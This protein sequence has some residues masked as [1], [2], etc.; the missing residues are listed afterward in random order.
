MIEQP[1][2]TVID[3]AIDHSD[4][5]TNKNLILFQSRTSENQEERTPA[6]KCGEPATQLPPL[7]FLQSSTSKTPQRTKKPTLPR[8]RLAPSEQIHL[9][10]PQPPPQRGGELF[11]HF[12]TIEQ[13]TTQNQT[14]PPRHG[15]PKTAQGQPQYRPTQKQGEKEDDTTGRPSRGR[16]PRA[17]SHLFLTALPSFKADVRLKAGCGPSA[18]DEAPLRSASYPTPQFRSPP[19]SPKHPLRVTERPLERTKPPRQYRCTSGAVPSPQNGSHEPRGRM[20]NNIRPLT[21]T[22][23]PVLQPASRLQPTKTSPH[24]RRRHPQ[25]P[26]QAPKRR[27]MPLPAL[28]LPPQITEQHLLTMREARIT[29]HPNRDATRRQ[30]KTPKN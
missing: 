29:Q 8:S 19:P 17:R 13:T 10:H 18:L 27:N 1:A 7:R 3:G 6:H 5:A 9:P 26:P 23:R 25:P 20:Q 12:Q 2:I 15:H 24:R 16:Q 30:G 28:K 4:R 22:A 11:A 14:P 21:P